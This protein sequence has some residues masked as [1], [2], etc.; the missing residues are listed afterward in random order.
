MKA[1]D[2]G[3]GLDVQIMSVVGVVHPGAMGG[4]LA[5]CLDAEVVWASDGRSEE[6]AN[7]AKSAGAQDLGTLER[8]ASE[9]D[10]IISV[11][12]PSAA[13]AI[14]SEVSGIEFDGLYVDANAISPDSARMIGATFERFVDGGLIGPP[15]QRAGDTR[16]YLSGLDASVVS[17]LFEG[18][19][20]DAVVV[21]DEPGKASALKMAFAA[22]TK[23]T[24]A[25]LIDIAALA[26]EEGVLDLLVKE[27]NESIPELPQRLDETAG[28]IGRKAWRFAGEMEQIAATFNTAGLPDGFHEAAGDVYRRLAVLKESTSN[29]SIQEIVALLLKREAP[30]G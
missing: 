10:V 1:N 21:G 17:E 15:P 18:S 3:F 24:S 26:E 25:L 12:P 19:V 11:C 8:L 5:A 30:E 16:F 14:A 7:R 4:A 29:E 20:L 6:T 27:W 2:T 28:R 22:W 9:S 23:G 13:V